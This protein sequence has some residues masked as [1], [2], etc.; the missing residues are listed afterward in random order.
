MATRNQLRTG[1]YLGEGADTSFNP[2]S[3]NYGDYFSSPSGYSAPTPTTSEQRLPGGLKSVNRQGVKKIPFTMIPGDPTGTK[4]PAGRVGSYDTGGGRTEG[5][6]TTVGGFQAVNTAYRSGTGGAYVDPVWGPTGGTAQTPQSGGRET[7]T[8]PAH[9]ATRNFLRSYSSKL[10]GAKGGKETISARNIRIE[11]ERLSGVETRRR[12]QAEGDKPF[13]V[14]TIQ[15]STF[16]PP[17]GP[18]PTLDLPKYEAQKYDTKRVE[19]LRQRMASGQIYASRRNLQR[20]YARSFAQYGFNPVARGAAMRIALEG[21]GLNVS[22][23][24]SSAEQTARTEYEQER[25]FEDENRQRDYQRLTT[26]ALES[27]RQASQAYQQQ[28]TQQ[29]TQETIYGVRDTGEESGIRVLNTDLPE[30]VTF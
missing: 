13:A 23:A 12:V 22:R 14:G 20:A 18:A 7:G 9:A 6:P 27:Y 19:Q 11:R 10:L 21:H 30:G 8:S 25:R 24:L 26:Q 28:G 16:V 4:I 3:Q 2:S 1:N 17:E 29:K 5:I 15:R